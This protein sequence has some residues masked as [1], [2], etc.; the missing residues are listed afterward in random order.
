MYDR[1]STNIHTLV[2]LTKSFPVKVG[3]HQGSTLSPF[4]FTIIIEEISK[5]IWETVPWC[6]LFADDIVLVGKTKEEVNR[7]LEEWKTMLRDKGLLISRKKT[8]YLRCHF[9]GTESISEPEVTIGGEVVACTT[10]FRYL[11]SVI[12]S[13]G[14]IDGDVT[15]RIQAGWLKW[16]A[17]SGV[18]CDRKFPSRLKLR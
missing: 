7:K 4:I 10:K 1:V 6:M 14:E 13:N 8:E 11:G 3:L 16:Q 9:S 5:S 2:G 18:L 17:A 15:N 12:H